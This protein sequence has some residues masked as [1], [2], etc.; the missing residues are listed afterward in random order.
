V[1]WSGEVDEVVV[2][3]D[4]NDAVRAS[5]HPTC[6]IF[7]CYHPNAVNV[8]NV[9]IFIRRVIMNKMKLKLIAAA[10]MALSTSAFAGTSDG[11]YVGIGIGEYNG[12]LKDPGVFSSITFGSTSLDT[13]GNLF[14]GYNWN[15]GAGSIALEASYNSNVGKLDSL[16]GQDLFKLDNNWQISVLPGYNF[17]KD[18]EGYVRLGWTQA[19]GTFGNAFS[20]V[21]ANTTHNFNGGVFGLGVDQ[22]VTQN[23]ALRLEWQYLY[24]S[25]STISY[26]VVGS[27]EWTPRSSGVDFSLRYAF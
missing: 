1:D 25:S 18:T 9:I 23:L 2:A 11:P 14:A 4:A 17:S 3:N 24:L 10:L 13:S 7:W 12:S 6:F 22:A 16:A 20:S 8:I 19:R 26:P 5:P 15:L 27:F 21:I